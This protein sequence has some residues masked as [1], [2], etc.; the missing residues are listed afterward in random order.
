MAIFTVLDTASS[1]LGLDVFAFGD[2]LTQRR[3]VLRGE[4]ITTPL[5]VEQVGGRGEISGDVVGSKWGTVDMGVGPQLIADE[6]KGY[7]LVHSS[8]RFVSLCTQV[9]C[10]AG[11]NWIAYFVHI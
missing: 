8:L 9:Y 11:I 7:L 5:A 10:P 4:E 2:A 3:M 6:N 1:L